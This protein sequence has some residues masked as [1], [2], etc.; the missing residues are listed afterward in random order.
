MGA[1][2]AGHVVLVRFPFSDLTASKLRPAVVLADA[3]EMTRYSVR[4][5]AT[6]T[7]IHVRSRWM[8]ATSS[9]G[10][11]SGQASPGQASSS[12]L[13][14]ASSREAPACSTPLN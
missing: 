6:H 3:V 4:S 8:Q 11:C 9:A 13:T 10:R 2:A 1:F 12:R 14:Q 5:P 7:A